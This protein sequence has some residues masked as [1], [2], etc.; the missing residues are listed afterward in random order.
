MEVGHD[1]PHLKDD[2]FPVGSSEYDDGTV[3]FDGFTY[4]VRGSIYYPAEEDGFKAA[5]NVQLAKLGGAPLVVC[6]HGANYDDTPSYQGYDYFQ[7]ELARMGFVAVSVDESEADQDGDWVDDRQNVVRRAELA[8]A[9]IA[10]LQ[11]LNANGPNFEGTM[12]FAKVGL[13]GHSRGG[14]CVI[15]VTERIKLAGVNI[16]AVLSLAPTD[17]EATNG[18]PD[19]YAFMTFLPAADCDIVENYGA[20]FYDQAAPAPVKAQLYIDHANH[21]YFNRKWQFDDTGGCLPVMTRP[22]HERILSTYGCAFFRSVLQGQPTLGFLDAT[23]RPPGV[24]HQFIHLAY[25]VTGARV[26]DDYEGHPITIDN[27]RQATAQI[28]GLVAEN[29]PF[30]QRQG[31]FNRSFFGNTNGNVSMVQQGTGQFREPLASPAD[32]THAEVRVRAAEVF[33]GP[34]VPATP[35]GFRV[36]VEDGKGI[37]AWMDVDDVGGLPRPFDRTAHDSKTKTML[38]TFRF[39]GYRFAAADSRL[40]IANIAAI[41]LELNRGDGRPIAFDDLEI[42]KS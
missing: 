15:A 11:Q 30:A 20:R 36:G 21:N 12:D 31:A 26:V 27:E 34:A 16:G 38:S 24:Q 1:K 13:M 28:D 32:L 18:R 19:G 2:P 9:S 22:D 25:A 10:F 40:N 41:L 35:T 23:Q 4:H 8:I 42:V 6:V 37:I 5:F 17:S 39:P 7:N 29:Y 3:S 33:Q 14:E